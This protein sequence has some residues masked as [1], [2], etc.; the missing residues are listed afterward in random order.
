[1]QRQPTPIAPVAR[2]DGHLAVDAEPG[3]LIGL[4]V[5]AAR[6]IMIESPLCGVLK[7]QTVVVAREV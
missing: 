7:S 1:V 4:V 2:H 5:T 6:I 3:E